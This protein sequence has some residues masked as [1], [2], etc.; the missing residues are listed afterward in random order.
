M[1]PRAPRSTTGWLGR[2]VSPRCL[3]RLGAVDH[4][5][6]LDQ[7]TREPRL[8]VMGASPEQAPAVRDLLADLDACHRAVEHPLLARPLDRGDAEGVPY[9]VFAVEARCDLD[10]VVAA[11]LRVQRLIPLPACRAFGDAL[12]GLL[13]AAHATSHPRGGAFVPVSV[14]SCANLMVS[15]DGHLH[16]VGLGQPADSLTRARVFS[17]LGPAHV[18]LPVAQGVPPSRLTDL[19]GLSQFFSSLMYGQLPEPVMRS[20]AG[21]T[22]GGDDPL[23][24]ILRRLSAPLES[25]WSD[26]ECVERYQ[27]G[28]ARAWE[29][30]GV[31]ADGALLDRTLQEILGSEAAARPAGSLAVARDGSSYVATDGTTVSLRRR[32]PLMRLVAGLVD[33]R[34]RCPGQALTMAELF[35]LGWPGEK[36]SDGTGTVSNRVYVALSTLRTLG[37]PG[38]Q[39]SPAGGYCLD[40][41]LPLYEE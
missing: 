26:E 14:F 27:E 31:A 39:R 38:L 22:Q 16:L 2:F 6:C 7:E 32:R 33:A 13:R 37:F 1:G 12:L 15:S 23:A 8:V 25:G 28:L 29:L 10:A 9:L 30:L 17:Q 24:V 4:V 5:A 19:A 41:A 34:R 20:L 40:P 3:R 21:L 35:A 36:A 11:A 18:A